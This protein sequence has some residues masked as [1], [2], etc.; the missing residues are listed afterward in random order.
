MS[1]RYQEILTALRANPSGLTTSQT[2]VWCQ[3][4]PGSELPDSTITGQCIYA[5]SKTQPPRVITTKNMDGPNVHQITEAGREYLAS[6]SD[7][8]TPAAPPDQIES[9]SLC[10]DPHPAT[11]ADIENEIHAALQSIGQLINVIGIAV[12]GMA[13]AETANPVI[14]IDDKS[15]KMALLSQLVDSPL[16]ATDVA[17]LLWEIRADIE[18]LGD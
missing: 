1:Y 15:E 7:S 9:A 11:A 18:R 6:Y 13:S 5:L 17:E 12:E 14:K 10:Q 4:Q 3:T 8:S 16:L 2:F